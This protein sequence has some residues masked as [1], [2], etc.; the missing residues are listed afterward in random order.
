MSKRPL[1][2]PPRP[3]HGYGCLDYE[4]WRAQRSHENVEHRVY[5]GVYDP[6]SENLPYRPWYTLDH[7]R[8]GQVITDMCNKLGRPLSICTIVDQE[9]SDLWM[10]LEH[11]KLLPRPKRINIAVVGNQ[12]LGKSSTINA[13]LSRN[14]VEIMGGSEAC[15]AFAT[16]IDYKDGAPDDTTVSDVKVTLLNLDEI[17]DLIE[18]H[19]R[20]YANLHAHATFDE[21]HGDTGSED[22][23][24]SVNG[25]LSGKNRKFSN[26]LQQGADTAVDFFRIMF[27]ADADDNAGLMVDEWL[28]EPDLEDGRFLGCLTKLATDHI[29]RIQEEEQGT[30]VYTGIS[31]ERLM[32]VRSRAVGI[33]PL[34]KSVTISTGSVLLRHGI[35]L[36]D[37]PGIVLL[38]L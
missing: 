17:R 23:D 2:P 3:A 10:A 16:I 38:L 12:G 14:L 34:V 11:A 27:N 6:G 35:C 18:E 36:L 7:N 8:I 28:K 13:L 24:V 33:W 32:E 9:I 29:S 15:T 1:F 20:R 30:L 5:G 21:E 4:A 22:S 19:I 26:E 25:P 37:L 31:D